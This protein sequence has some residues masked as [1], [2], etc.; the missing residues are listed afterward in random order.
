M[1]DLITNRWYDI[2]LELLEQKDENAIK[3]IKEN[4]GDISKCCTEMLELWL[5]RSPIATWDQLIEALKAPGINLNDAASKI[6][7]MLLPSTEGNIHNVL[8][9]CN[10]LIPIYI[11]IFTPNGQYSL[12]VLY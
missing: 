4:T 7:G 6:E 11:S 12:Y 8:Y 9:I 5:N 1:R 10:I 2:G 3:I